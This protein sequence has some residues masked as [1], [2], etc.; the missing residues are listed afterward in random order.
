MKCCGFD[1]D[2]NLGTYE[3]KPC[4]QICKWYDSIGDKCLIGMED[5]ND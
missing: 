4:C 3:D 2:K 5:S 1:L